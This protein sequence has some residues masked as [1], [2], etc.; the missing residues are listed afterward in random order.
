[1][2]FQRFLLHYHTHSFSCILDLLKLC[3]DNNRVIN[4]FTWFTLLFPFSQT[5]TEMKIAFSRRWIFVT[6]RSLQI[7]HTFYLLN[8]SLSLQQL[9]NFTL[10][11]SFIY[12]WYRVNVKK[13]YTWTSMCWCC[14]NEQAEK[15]LDFSLTYLDSYFFTLEIFVLV[16]VYLDLNC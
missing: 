9:L 8:L 1:M 11:Q 12:T 3:T 2:L 13:L 6:N 14:S 5:Y 10:T 7:Y 16:Y 4:L 15:H